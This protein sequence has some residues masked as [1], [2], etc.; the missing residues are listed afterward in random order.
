Q[1]ARG[2]PAQ[3]A[4]V[5]ANPIC[6]Q[7]DAL[8]LQAPSREDVLSLLVSHRGVLF[9]YNLVTALTHIATLTTSGSS[10][11]TK[12][13]TKTVSMHGRTYEWNSAVHSR[14]LRDGRFELLLR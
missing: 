14:L 3:T 9:V 13:K 5:Y 10:T 6:R 4:V 12:N 1:A 11:D 8:I 7:M 2:R